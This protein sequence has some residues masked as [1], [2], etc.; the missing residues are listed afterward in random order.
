MMI[1]CCGMNSSVNNVSKM[2]KAVLFRTLLLSL[3]I[4]YIDTVRLVPGSW[5]GVGF[6]G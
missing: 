6:P 2:P 4:N 1:I 5:F 3:F